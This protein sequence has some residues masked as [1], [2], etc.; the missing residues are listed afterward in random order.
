M[1]FLHVTEN[2]YSLV[3]LVFQVIKHFCV[4]NDFVIYKYK[5]IKYFKHQ[6]II[7]YEVQL[8]CRAFAYCAKCLGYQ[9]QA[10]DGVYTGILLVL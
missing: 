5:Y 2:F 4:A 6:A 3:K 9:I 1:L 10:C 7:R 8:S